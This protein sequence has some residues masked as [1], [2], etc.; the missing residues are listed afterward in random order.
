MSKIKAHFLPDNF[1]WLRGENEAS[2]RSVSVRYYLFDRRESGGV[3]I[4]FTAQGTL[5]EVLNE[6][7][8]W[9]ASLHA[10]HFNIWDSVDEGAK[11]VKSHFFSSEEEKI[12][13]KAKFK[14]VELEIL[15]RLL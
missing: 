3:K 13:L 14:I 6:G 15:K 10:S 9:I 4:T 2:K 12:P 11:L 7:F 1:F 5:N 8:F